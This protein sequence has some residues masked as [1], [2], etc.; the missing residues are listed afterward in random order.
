MKK[1]V[2]YFLL[3]FVVISCTQQNDVFVPTQKDYS[4]QIQNLDKIYAEGLQSGINALKT[5][6]TKTGQNELLINRSLIVQGTLK[7]FEGKYIITNDDSFSSNFKNIGNITISQNTQ[8]SKFNINQFETFT[9][10][11]K[12]IAKPFIENLLQIENMSVAKKLAKDFQNNVVEISISDNEKLEL[13]A[14]GSATIALADFLDSNQSDIIYEV[15]DNEL[16]GSYKTN[17]NARLAKG[18]KISAKNVLAGGVVGLAV[19]GVKG[20]MAGCAGGTVVFL[21]LGTATGCV[22]GAVIGGA[23]GFIEGALASAAAELLTSCGH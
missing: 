15:L 11:Q 16:N 8:P 7:T 22:G 1:I 4:S 2:A 18:C 9:S 19:G 6:I 10:K 12:E 14:L 17:A 23:L 21:G 20:G 5:S 13:F 3:V